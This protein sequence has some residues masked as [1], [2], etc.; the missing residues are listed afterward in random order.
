MYILILNPTAGQGTALK[1]LPEIEAVF[2]ERGLAYRVVESPNRAD[3]TLTARKAAEDGVDGV[4][5]IGGDGSLFA[6]VNGLAGSDVPLI[7]VP[8]GTGNDF[9]RCLNLPKDPVDALRHQLNMPVT[10]IDLGKMNDVYFLNVAGTGFDVDVLRVVE[11]YKTRYKGLMAYLRGLIDAI[12]AYRPTVARVSIDGGEER[13]LQFAILSIGNGRFIGGGMK[14]CPES[15]VNDGLF[16]LII[17]NPVKKRS[18][19]VLIAFY[20]AGK[21]VSLGLGKLYRCK[22]VTI[23]RSGMTVNLDGELLD[24][25]QACFQLLPSALKVRLSI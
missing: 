15:T 19:P 8:C 20:I 13:E 1:R 3:A 6:V 25:D 17:V 12:K 14:A 4:V 9:V 24:A 5:A 11:K 18:I 2:M 16:D 23:R 21:H 22:T 7:F 10:S